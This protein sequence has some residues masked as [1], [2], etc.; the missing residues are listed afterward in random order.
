MTKSLQEAARDLMNQV[1]PRARGETI[2]LPMTAIADL[3]DALSQS[4]SVSAAGVD[5][6]REALTACADAI[7]EQMNEGAASDLEC[8]VFAKLRALLSRKRLQA[9]RHG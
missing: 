1:H 8:E 9:V 4:P 6:Y 7:S 3:R 2:E 5:E